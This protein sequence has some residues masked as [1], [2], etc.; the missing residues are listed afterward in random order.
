MSSKSLKRVFYINSIALFI[1]AIVIAIM[2]LSFRMNTAVVDGKIIALEEYIDNNKRTAFIPVISYIDSGGNEHINK[3]S[4]ATKPPI[5]KIG[6]I[7]RVRYKINNPER[8][9]IESTLWNWV[10]PIGLA[11]AGTILLFLGY[12]FHEKEKLEKH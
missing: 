12:M 7:I 9:M 3:Q 6:D 2:N 1:I 10:L 11:I 8:M 4:I 5:G